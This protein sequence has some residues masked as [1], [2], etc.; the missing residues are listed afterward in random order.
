MA[1]APRRVKLRTS[2]NNVRDRPRRLAGYRNTNATAARNARIARARFAPRTGKSSSNNSPAF[3]SLRGE[4]EF[5]QPQVQRSTPQPHSLFAEPTFQVAIKPKLVPRPMSEFMER[6][7]VEVIG[8][9][10]RCKSWK[11]LI[12]IKNRPRCGEGRQ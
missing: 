11:A 10:E 3:S 6:S 9:L 7:V 2:A 4:V 1:H 12:E 5:D 8:T